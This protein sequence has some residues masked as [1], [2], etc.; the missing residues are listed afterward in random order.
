GVP[1]RVRHFNE[2]AW[3]GST[4]IVGAIKPASEWDFA[5]GSTISAFS[6]YLTL[7]NPSSTPA[8]VTIN[9]V[10]DG[11]GHPTKGLTLPANSRT[12]I[13]VFRG[14]LSTNL[15]C[16]LSGSASN[17]GV[18]PGIVGVSAQVLSA[19]VPFVVDGP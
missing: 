15:T 4:A 19:S 6:E 3:H 1:E 18:G 17:C 14:D 16:T 13:P 5:E 12:T 2:G 10:T 11:T 9:Y 7:Q 8:P